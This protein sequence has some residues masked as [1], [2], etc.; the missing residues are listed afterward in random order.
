MKVTT[1]KAKRVYSPRNQFGNRAIVYVNSKFDSMLDKDIFMPYVI[2]LEYESKAWKSICRSANK[3]VAAA[4]KEHLQ[5]DYK[6]TYSRKA[7]CN[8]GCSPGFIVARH[9]DYTQPFLMHTEMWMDVEIEDV[10]LTN[11]QIN[12]Y[13]KFHKQHTAELNG[14]L[15]TE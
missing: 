15:V 4:I 6:V 9:G 5:A 13:G 11:F 14:H 10:E 7:G 3:L 8:C 2:D 12:N 1:T